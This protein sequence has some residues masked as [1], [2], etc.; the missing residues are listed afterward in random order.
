MFP[1]TGF[2]TKNH[3]AEASRL[4]GKL[5]LSSFGAESRVVLQIARSIFVGSLAGL[6]DGSHAPQVRRSRLPGDIRQA[7]PNTRDELMR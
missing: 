3:P 4:D 7:I 1:R 6:R 2:A 5:D